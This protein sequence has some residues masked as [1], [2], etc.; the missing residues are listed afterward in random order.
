MK[1]YTKYLLLLASI[2]SFTSCELSEDTLTESNLNY[3]TFKQ[4][5]ISAGVDPGSTTSVD[6]VVYTAN[7]TGSDRTFNVMVDENSTAA[8]GSYM[9]PA[10]VT[11][12]SGSNEGTLT[13]ELSDVNIGI[14]V[15]ELILNFSGESGLYTGDKTSI[16]YIQNCNEVTGSL[17]IVFD[18]YG[19]ETSWEITDSLGGVVYSASEGDYTDG[20]ATA[21]V[22][23]TLCAGRDFKFVINDSYGDGLSWPTN[24]TY[25]LTID[26]QVKAQGGGDFG[27]SEETSFDTK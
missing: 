6:V 19:S 23:I 2:I 12:P 8:D 14:G 27:S 10:T 1:K 15:N 21:S 13:V 5:E 11:V 7:K 26:G 20:Q 24:G 18:G 4:S 3:V 17:E 16:K 25:T 9:V 22:A